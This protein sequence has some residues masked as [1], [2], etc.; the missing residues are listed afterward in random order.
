[1]TPHDKLAAEIAEKLA[2]SLKKIRGIACHQEYSPQEREFDKISEIAGNAVFEWEQFELNRLKAPSVSRPTNEELTNSIAMYKQQYESVRRYSRQYY[3]LA[4]MQG[5]IPHAGEFD[6]VTGLCV[7]CGCCE[8]KDIHQRYVSHPTAFDQ[9]LAVEDSLRREI[10]KLKDNSP[11]N[12]EIAKAIIYEPSIN[13]LLLQSCMSGPG[14][15]AVE[16][17]C[18]EAGTAALNKVRT[19]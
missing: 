11:T 13:K 7:L 2:K 18:I 19:G 9:A 3:K 16:A 5:S 8:S 6:K 12:E 15:D 10:V 17:R 1:M 4:V 14:E